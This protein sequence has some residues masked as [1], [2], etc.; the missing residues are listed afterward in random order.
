[1][2]R[3]HNFTPSI[4]VKWHFCVPSAYEN[5]RW[6]DMAGAEK[7][8][9][10]RKLLQDIL[11]IGLIFSY[12]QSSDHSLINALVITSSSYFDLEANI[13]RKHCDKVA[14]R[15]SPP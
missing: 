8:T 10:A 7:V 9:R 13:W 14:P 4:I 12:D 15:Q 3:A 2:Y 1:M 5:A 6:I 11:S